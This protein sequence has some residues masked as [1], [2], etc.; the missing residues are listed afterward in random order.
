M[1]PDNTPEKAYYTGLVNNQ[2][3]IWEGAYNITNG[4]FPP[5]NPTCPNYSPFTSTDKWCWGRKVIATRTGNGAPNP[6]GFADQGDFYAPQDATGVFD[7]T[8]S[9][10]TPLGHIW[11]ANLVQVVYGRIKELGFGI[12]AV[13]QYW[14]RFNINLVL[15]PNS[16]PYHLGDYSYPLVQ[17]DNGAYFSTWAAWKASYLPTYDAV[18]LFNSRS[19]DPEFGYP[20]IAYAALSYAAGVTAGS[21][22][23]NDAWTWISTNLPNQNLLNDNPKWAILPRAA[24]PVLPP[25]CDLDGNGIVDANDVQISISRALGQGVCGNGDVDRDGR[26]TVIDTQRIINAAGGASCRIGP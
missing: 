12:G 3:Q 23:G 1:A 16:S 14:A 4:S 7:P 25:S 2:I 21:F 5:A 9:G 15:D 19:V 20:Q 26:C 13:Q 24:I 22:N 11:E 18:S 17:V 10:T 6:L 8:K